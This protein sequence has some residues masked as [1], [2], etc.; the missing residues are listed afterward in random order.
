MK[1][2]KIELNEQQLQIILHALEGYTRAGTEQYDIMFEALTKYKYDYNTNK[3]INKV[4]RELTDSELRENESHGIHNKK[5]DD[6]YRK[7]YDMI[8][9]LRYVKSW[10]N[11]EAS[12]EDRHENFIK[13]MGINFDEPYKISTEDCELIK[14]EEIEDEEEA[15]FNDID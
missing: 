11:V 13:Y 3:A 7:A 2:Y 1:K 9:V 8:Q 4:V 6:D 10:A 12:P 5:I 14:C 15:F